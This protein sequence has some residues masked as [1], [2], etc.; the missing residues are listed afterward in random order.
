V[1]RLGRR[2]K[3]SEFFKQ[4]KPGISSKYYSVSTINRNR[5]QKQ[6]GGLNLDFVLQYL[7]LAHKLSVVRENKRKRGLFMYRIFLKKRNRKKP[8]A[9]TLIF[10]LILPILLRSMFLLTIL[11]AKVLM[12]SC[13]L[14][15]PLEPGLGLTQCPENLLSNIVEFPD[16]PSERV[17]AEL[18]E[19]SHQSL[20][21]HR[22][23]PLLAFSGQLSCLPAHRSYRRD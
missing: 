20:H 12:P 13:I 15:V 8:M 17:R 2:A 22:E 19:V 7:F 16:L 6:L 18:L 1:R 14:R 21:H 23:T 9:S 5:S 10:F 11:V 4:E 3:R